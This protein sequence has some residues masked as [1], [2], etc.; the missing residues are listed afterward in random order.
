MSQKPSR[1]KLSDNS[2]GQLET[3][4]YLSAL[5]KV[6]YKVVQTSVQ[7]VGCVQ[8]NTGGRQP[9]QR[10]ERIQPMRS[11]GCV[12]TIVDIHQVLTRKRISI[13]GRQTTTDANPRHD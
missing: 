2:A 4:C 8:P 1:L 10:A 13:Q 7:L 3:R 5:F 9:Y 6:P 12:Q 11:Q